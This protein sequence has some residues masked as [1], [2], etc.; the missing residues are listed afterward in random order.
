LPLAEQAAERIAQR[1]VRSAIPKEERL[2]K[3]EVRKL[4]EIRKHLQG[5]P[6][7]DPKVAALLDHLHAIFGAEPT[8]KVIIFTEYL[9]T[10]EAIREALDGSEDLAGR[11]TEL[12]GGWPR[13]RRTKA[14][15]RFELPDIRILLATDAASEG[16]NLQ[17]ACRRL[18]HV[19]LPWNP[20]R[21]EQ[22]NG[23]VDRYGQT[24]QPEIRYL[25]YPDS[26]E[27]FVL[28]ALVRKIEQMQGD[29]VST[30]DIL[31]VLSGAEALEQGLVTLDGE[32]TDRQEAASRL[33][34][35]FEDR[36]AEFVRTV[37]PLVLP[38]RDARAEIESAERTLQT[39]EPLL[40]DDL[41]LE[42]FLTDIL[43]AGGF[44][45][46]GEDGLFRVAVPRAF[47]GV[48]VLP[49]YPRTT[50][51]RSVAVRTRPAE[52]EFLTPLHPLVRA[53]ADDARRRFLQVYADDRGLPAKRLAARRIPAGEAP[54]ILF[55]FFGTVEGTDGLVQEAVIPVRC[56]LDGQSTGDNE[57]D[58]RLLTDVGS[59]GEVSG[60]LLGPLFAARF[61]DCCAAAQTEATRRL[62]ARVDAIRARRSREAQL[63]RDDML[64]YAEDRRRELDEEERFVTGRED[65]RSGQQFLWAAQPKTGFDARRA[66]VDTFVNRRQEEIEAFV[67]IRDPAPPRP[68]GAL[69]LVPEGMEA[70]P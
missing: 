4:T 27:D 67:I 12:R 46:T 62:A 56:G 47:Q 59:A 63:L 49:I 45:P 36:T 35:L 14:Q 50:C 42:R 40:A 31:G 52:V 11:Y 20:N 17:R 39:A 32:A 57:N 30:P 68:L 19:E 51:R 5:L 54:G 60:A 70:A 64:R 69:L 37:Q 44:S 61:G 65:R 3:A 26:P 8:E 9:D 66:A 1:I 7:P 58:R 38:G 21:L 13:G 6:G 10:L 29:R 22:R 23:R 43:G 41:E 2:R 28:D 15:I 18:I 25:F 33:V 16:L 34:R 48:G 24:R 55:T 53:I